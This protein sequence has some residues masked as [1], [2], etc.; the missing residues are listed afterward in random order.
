MCG[1]KT[2]GISMTDKE[3]FRYRMNPGEQAVWKQMQSQ[4]IET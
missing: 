4:I 3:L 1:M 2:W